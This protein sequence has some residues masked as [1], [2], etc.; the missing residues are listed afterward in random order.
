MEDVRQW[1][2]SS[3]SKGMA[4]GLPNTKQALDRLNLKF[5]NTHIFHVA[6]SNGK[7]TTCAILAASV[8]LSGHSAVLFSSPHVSRIEE[9]IRI[10]GR[11]I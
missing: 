11:F 6:G 4:L 5:D 9:R 2:N 7:G 8:Q 3:K 10:D 1:L